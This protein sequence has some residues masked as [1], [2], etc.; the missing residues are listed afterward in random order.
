M[1]LSVRPSSHIPTYSGHEKLQPGERSISAWKA[2]VSADG[3]S[4]TITEGS[5]GNEQFLGQTFPI[6]RNEF[7]G[8]K[9]IFKA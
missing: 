7:G 9:I 5:D 4:V 1:S 2:E 8:G 3:Q 6:V